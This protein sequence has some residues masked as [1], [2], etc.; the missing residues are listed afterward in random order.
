MEQVLNGNARKVKCSFCTKVVS[1]GIYRFKHHL[2]GTSDDSGP[3]ALVSDE[4]K[5]EMLKW[6]AALEEA[7]KKKRKMAEIAQGNVTENPTFEVEVS[8]QKGKG[9][10]SASETQTKI[11]AIVK[12]NP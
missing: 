4:A 12:K 11:D 8:Q 9:K 7:T 10:A 1:G 5:M 2:A 6:V 3:C